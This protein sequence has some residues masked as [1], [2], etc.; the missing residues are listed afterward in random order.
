MVP[1]NGFEPLKVCLT[2]T[3][4][5]VMEMETGADGTKVAVG[6]MKP[7]GKNPWVQ[8]ECT[9]VKSIPGRHEQDWVSFK[10]HSFVQRAARRAL[11]SQGGFFLP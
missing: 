7:W 10:V 5:P 6:D 9:S 4:T 11:C 2:T 8:E 1:K 3:T